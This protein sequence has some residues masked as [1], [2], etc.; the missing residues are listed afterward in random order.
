MSFLILRKEPIQNPICSVTYAASNCQH[1]SWTTERSAFKF[2]DE[3]TGCD[4]SEYSAD[5][6]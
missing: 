2:P 5:N 4:G 1:N 3:N 6:F